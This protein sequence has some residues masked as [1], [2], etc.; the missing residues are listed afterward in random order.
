MYILI[1]GYGKLLIEMYDNESCKIFIFGGSNCKII[2]GCCLL[3][4]GG[5]IVRE[6]GIIVIIFS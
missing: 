2:K 3:L 5:R 6:F 1:R 4:L